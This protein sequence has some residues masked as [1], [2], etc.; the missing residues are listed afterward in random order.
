[1]AVPPAPL[2]KSRTVR[3]LTQAL[4]AGPFRRADIGERIRECLVPRTKQQ[5]LSPLVDRLLTDF[6]EGRRPTV[7]AVNSWM[8]SDEELHSAWTIKEVILYGEVDPTSF[9]QRMVPAEGAAQSWQVP[10]ATILGELA[11]LLEL[12]IDDLGWLTSRAGGGARHYLYRWHRKRSGGGG[13][14][15]AIPKP[16]LRQSQRAVLDRILEKIPVHDAAHGFFRGRSVRSAVGKHC[17]QGMVLR[18]DLEDFFPSVTA[19]RIAHL[20]LTA[21]YPE[22]VARA[23][24]WL[25]TQTPSAEVL[26]KCP[27]GTTRSALEKMRVPH[28]PQGAPSSPAL[29]NLAAFRLDCRLAGLAKSAKAQYTRYADDLIFSGAGDDFGRGTKRFAVTVAAIC[30]ECG[31]SVAHRKTRLM[32]SGVRQRAAGVILNQHPNV[33]REDFDRLKATLTNCERHGAAEQNR[34]GREDF[35]AHLAGRVAWVTALNPKRGEKLR[36]IFERIAF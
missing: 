28:L 29:A 12:H 14:L 17:G 27:H 33:S 9:S 34:E 3:L 6:P 4:V 19:G 15:I 2:T 11:D 20:F 8:K 25:S 18:M 21:G 16:L 30:I 24:S 5:W 1:M 7:R 22:P 23:L 36:R 32:R 35:R 10:P 13:R 26:A 31:F